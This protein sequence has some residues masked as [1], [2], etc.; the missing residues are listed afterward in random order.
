MKPNVLFH[1]L[2]LSLALTGATEFTLFSQEAD[3]PMQKTPDRPPPAAGGQGFFL[4]GL[5]PV[6]N[7]LTDEQRASFRQAME[8]QRE[9]MRDTETKLR[10]ARGK[11]IESGLAGNFDEAAVRRQAMVVAILEADAAVLRARALSQLQPPLSLEQL[12]KI[13]SGLAAAPFRNGLRNA[14]QSE[15]AAE[16]RHNNTSTN[17]DENNLPP[18][19]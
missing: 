16:R 12:E 15:P 1:G 5:G 11:L 13:K 19:R 8:S 14:N 6:G 4:A 9:K 3:P 2:L 17:R 18:K 10:E 7:V